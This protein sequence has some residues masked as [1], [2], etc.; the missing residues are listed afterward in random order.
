[1]FAARVPLSGLRVPH[2]ALST[3]SSLTIRRRSAARVYRSTSDRLIPVAIN[4]DTH[5]HARLV[6]EV[7]RAGS[8]RK[9][10]QAW[11]QASTMAR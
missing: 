8:A 10:F 5:A 2:H 7:T 3:S 9:S 6:T 1:M 11:R 4:H